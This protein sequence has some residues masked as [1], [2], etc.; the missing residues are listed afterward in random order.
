MVYTDIHVAHFRTTVG[1][2]DRDHQRGHDLLER[3][4]LPG[5]TQEARAR[6]HGAF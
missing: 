2:F 1:D 5:S 6:R 3:A 4:V